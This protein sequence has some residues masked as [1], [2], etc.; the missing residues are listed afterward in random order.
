MSTYPDFDEHENL[1]EIKNISSQEKRASRRSSFGKK[2]RKP[3]RPVRQNEIAD[4]LKQDDSQGSLNFTYQASRHEREWLNGSLGGFFEHKWFEDVLRLLKGGK[5]A[6]VYQCTANPPVEAPYLAAKVYRPRKFR[7]LKND[8][9]YRTG[10]VNLD[11]EGR[12]ITNDGML[13]AIRKGTTFGKELLHT[14]WIEH[15]YKAMQ[16]LHSAGADVPAPYACSNNA[17][18]MAYIGGDDLPAPTLSSVNLPHRQARPLY[19]RVLENIEIM[20]SHGLVHADLSA[21]NILYWEGQITLIDFPQ[22]IHPLV[23]RSAYSIFQ[24][25]ILRVCEYFQCQGV[26]CNPSRLAADLWQTFGFP[27]QTEV[28]PRLLEGDS[29]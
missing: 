1:S 19:R 10:R 14:S 13:H 21:Y 22:V 9:V 15:E 26:E 18:L 11:S 17:I 8:H 7:S 4:M 12:Q 25:D 16:T 24:R 27:R 6:S 29:L 23:N 2:K 20:L 5:E 3:G 28:D